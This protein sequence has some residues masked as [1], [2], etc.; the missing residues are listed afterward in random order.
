M[1]LLQLVPESMRTAVLVGLTDAK[2]MTLLLVQRAPN[3]TDGFSMQL[4]EEMD[5]PLAVLCQ[6]LLSQPSQLV[7][8]TGQGCQESGQIQGLGAVAGSR[9][10]WALGRNR[11]LGM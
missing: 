8:A 6:I 3:S 9:G 11:G 10:C 4:A 1:E 7:R 5:N 2:K